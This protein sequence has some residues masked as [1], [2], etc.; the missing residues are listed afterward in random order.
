MFRFRHCGKS[1]ANVGIG[2]LPSAPTEVE[3]EVLANEFGKCGTWTV[4]EE[5]VS[6][7]IT[8]T[9]LFTF[10]TSSSALSGLEQSWIECERGDVHD[11][12]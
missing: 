8:A 1:C 7:L 3:D 10:D 6:P 5:A 12:D 11:L 4:R 9:G 2:V